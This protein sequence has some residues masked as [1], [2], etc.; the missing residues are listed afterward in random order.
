[1]ALLVNQD[2]ELPEA[3]E[4]SRRRY[5]TI[6]KQDSKGMSRVH[7]LLDPQAR[8]TLDAVLAKLGAPG[9]C[10]PE[11]RSPCVDGAPTD[12]AVHGDTRSQG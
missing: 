3:A 9:M 6:E 4:R 12:A 2:G 11:D 7:G 1:M 5:L 10:N 8:A